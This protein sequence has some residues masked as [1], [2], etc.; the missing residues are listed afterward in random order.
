MKLVCLYHDSIAYLGEKIAVNYILL[1]GMVVDRWVVSVE[2]RYS[3]AN[4]RKVST[5]I[6][7]SY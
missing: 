2:E 5:R 1:Q 4:T 3:R 6:E 7:P